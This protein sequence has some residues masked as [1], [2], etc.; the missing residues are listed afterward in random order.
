[1]QAKQLVENLNSQIL[2]HGDGPIL[3]DGLKA[4]TVHVSTD[5]TGKTYY[6]FINEPDTPQPLPTKPLKAS[7]LIHQLH[8]L[9]D[10]CGD[11]IVSGETQTITDCYIFDQ[12]DGSPGIT[13]VHH[14]SPGTKAENLGAET[15]PDTAA[16]KC[17]TCTC[18][19]HASQP[20]RE[21]K[22]TATMPTIAHDL[23]RQVQELVASLDKAR[24]VAGD[25]LKICLAD[26]RLNG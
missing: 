16:V 7:E 10:D 12:E 6:S 18:S 8:M 11:V 21:M 13:L 15:T 23:Y 1:M 14:D 9:I 24:D 22:P 3:A 20:D 17:S 19:C 25:V 4:N 26:I 5:G 2:L